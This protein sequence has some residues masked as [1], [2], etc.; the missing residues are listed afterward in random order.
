M[1]VSLSN[2]FYFSTE[3]VGVQLVITFVFA[4]HV[5]YF[6]SWNKKI[7]SLLPTKLRKSKSSNSTSEPTNSNNKYIDED[8]GEK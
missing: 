8:L 7:R 4:F 3:G 2:L 5:S 6:I 1:R